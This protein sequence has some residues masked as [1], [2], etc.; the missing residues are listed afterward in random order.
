MPVGGTAGSL[1]PSL[2]IVAIAGNFVFGVLLNFGIGHYAPTLVMFSLMGMDPRLAFP[3]MAGGGALAAQEL[4]FVTSASGKSTSASPRALLLVASQLFYLLPL[5]SS[6]CQSRCCAGSSASSCSIPR[7]SCSGPLSTGVE[8]TGRGRAH[9]LLRQGNE[10]EGIVLRDCADDHVRMR[11]G[12]CELREA[13]LDQVGKDQT[14]RLRR[15]LVDVKALS[16]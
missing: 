4:A 16:A 8:R 7:W 1:P 3:I 5:S 12:L 13:V 11:R 2:T 9:S 6:P 15:A 14:E 10:L